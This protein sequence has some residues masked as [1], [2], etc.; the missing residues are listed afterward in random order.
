MLRILVSMFWFI[1]VASMWLPNF[2][3]NQFI[4]DNERKI[5]RILAAISAVLSVYAA[6]FA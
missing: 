2:L 5:T 6:Y 3:K 4:K 1:T